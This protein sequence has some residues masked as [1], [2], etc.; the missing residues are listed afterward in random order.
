[1]GEGTAGP[2]P[3]SLE[4]RDQRT[5]GGPV[6]GGRR[7]EPR[8]T[9]SCRGAFR[10][11]RP[12]PKSGQA[13]GTSEESLH[14]DIQKL[15]EKRD[16]LDKEISQFVSE[17]Y[18]VDELEDHITQLHEYND[19]KDVGQMLMGKL[20]VIRGVTTKELYPEFGLDMND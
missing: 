4:T 11:P 10:S 2:G 8:L 7:T 16:M 6:W 20:A 13:D 18:S 3:R 12:L 19:I 1:M 5:P 14:L 15:K 9:R 17:G